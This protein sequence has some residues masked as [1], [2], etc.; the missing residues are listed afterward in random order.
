MALARDHPRV[1]Q[2]LEVLGERLLTEV[3]ERR[4][5]A[6]ADGLGGRLA[7]RIDDPQARWVGRAP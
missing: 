7:Q 2:D 4:E 1:T 6:L 3:E 5:L